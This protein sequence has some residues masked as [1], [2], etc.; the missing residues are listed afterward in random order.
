MHM[1]KIVIPSVVLCTLLCACNNQNP[2]A[3][4]STAEKEVATDSVAGN[5]PINDPSRKIIHTA[6]FRCR[7]KDVFEATDK[8]EKMVL[9]VGGQVS[10]SDLENSHSVVNTQPYTVD[11]L[12]QVTE[13]TTTA[14]LTLRIPVRI[15]DSVLRQVPQ[16]A[17][18]IDTRKLKLEDASYQYLANEL[19]SSAETDLTQAALNKSKKTEDV[20][21]VAQYKDEQKQAQIDRK[22]NN[23]VLQNRADYAT[24][25]IDLFQPAKIDVLIIANT[26]YFMKPA[27]G[28][29]LQM[30]T[31]GG[32]E[33][34]EGLFVFCVNIWP[35]ILIA[36][37]LYIFYKKFLKKWIAG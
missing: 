24:V 36:I 4:Y 20:L 9:S 5:A 18:F 37:V 35:L 22:I 30:A 29:R 31:I 7:V 28:K 13:Y 10:Q 6:D 15:V 34:F 2:N 1:L 17:D 21:T 16:Y 12:K 19:H 32:W 14:H 27:F 11:S 3:S 23:M 25:N 26:E 8:I 33:M